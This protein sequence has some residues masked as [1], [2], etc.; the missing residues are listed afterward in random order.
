MK[1]MPPEEELAYYQLARQHQFVPLIYAYRPNLRIEGDKAALDWSEFDQ[2]LARY[3][4]GSA[5]TDRHGYSGPGYGLPLADLARTITKIVAR[6]APMKSYKPSP[7]Q[8][9]AAEFDSSAEEMEAPAFS[10]PDCGG[11]IMQIQKGKGVQFRCHVGH[12]FSLDSFTEAHS[13]A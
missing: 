13:D 9:E 3:L 11:A 5:F 8:C 4:D 7:E 2:R 12:K 10:C 6:T 1:N